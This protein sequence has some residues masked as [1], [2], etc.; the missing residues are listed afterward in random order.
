MDIF[1]AAESGDSGKMKDIMALGDPAVL[2]ATTPEG[3][4]CLHIASMRGHQGFCEDVLAINGSLLAAVN[5]D[6]ET[7][8]L[9][10]VRKGHA[11]LASYLLGWCRYLRLSEAVLKQDKDGCNALHHALL[12]SH[13]KLAL[14]LIEAEPELAKAVNKDSKSPM[15]IAIKRGCVDVFDKLVTMKTRKP[16]WK[17]AYG[18]R[19]LHATAKKG[20]SGENMLPS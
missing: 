8:L 5:V 4:T 1:E 20:N 11:S 9:T 15:F 14:E 12:R 17:G 3:N 6:G 18:H 19:A 2:L 10:A 7:P 13:R 16:S